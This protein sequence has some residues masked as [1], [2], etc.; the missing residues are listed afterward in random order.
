MVI[1]SNTVQFTKR[2]GFYPTGEYSGNLSNGGEWIVIGKPGGD[3]LTALLYGDDVAWPPLADGV[4]HSMVPVDIN[5]DRDQSRPA[6]WRDSYHI[7]G[8]P[9]R[10]DTESTSVEPTLAGSAA[11]QLRQNYPNPFT[12][13]TQIVY[14]LPEEGHVEL[15]VYNLMGQK[16]SI[17]VA[18]R[19]QAG[20]HQVTW[21][22]RDDA[23][24]QIGEGIYFYRMTVRDRN[25]EQ[26]LTRKMIRY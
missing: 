4:G 18:S 17:L 9:G 10:D 14:T 22:G 16:I 6:Y 8:S 21:D 1:A 11:Y 15:S 24:I 26:R 2:Y 13:L 12:H 23:G 25:G 7:G 3:T 20:T 19:Q 5:P